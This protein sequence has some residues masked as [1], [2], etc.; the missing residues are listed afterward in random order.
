MLVNQH[1]SA[2]EINC[3]KAFLFDLIPFDVP[4]PKI[5]SKRDNT[6]LALLWEGDNG[7]LELEFGMTLS[8]WFN[9]DHD[10]QFIL[11]QSVEQM[12]SWIKKC[13]KQV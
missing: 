2:R 7:S 5:K 8:A 13:N 3:V 11:F 9:S 1:Y 6:L 12:A 4:T 10:S